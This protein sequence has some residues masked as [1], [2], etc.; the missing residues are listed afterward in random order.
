MSSMAHSPYTELIEA[1]ISREQEVIGSEAITLAQSIDGIDVDDTGNVLS[2]ER[3][4]KEILN[5][6]VESYVDTSGDVAAFLIARRIDNL[7]AA[8]LD[9]PDV[10]ERHM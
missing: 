8:D 6:L 3:C 10:L 4:G 7:P 2:L 9:L 1:A 5:E